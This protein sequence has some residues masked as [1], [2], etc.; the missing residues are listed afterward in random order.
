MPNAQFHAYVRGIL[1]KT[2]FTEIYFCVYIAFD[3][4]LC[5]EFHSYIRGT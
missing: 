5:K 2:G 3:T 1:K 4:K